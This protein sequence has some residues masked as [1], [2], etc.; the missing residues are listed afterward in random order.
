MS[1]GVSRLRF[2]V[3]TLMRDVD[4][5]A[6][7]HELKQVKF[8]EVPSWKRLKLFHLLWRAVGSNK[9]E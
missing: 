6:V 5:D 3:F 4:V 9:L 7:Y 1:G 2:H 8:Y